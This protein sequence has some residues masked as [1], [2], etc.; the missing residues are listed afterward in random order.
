MKVEAAWCRTVGEDI[1]GMPGTV[2]NEA[3]LTEIGVAVE[4][5][6]LTRAVD[7]RTGQVRA[8]M[9][10]GLGGSLPSE[11]YLSIVAYLLQVNGHAA[12]PQALT[13]DAVA[14]VGE[15]G[16]APARGAPAAATYNTAVPT[17]G[18]RWRGG[19]A[20]EGCSG[21]QPTLAYGNRR[22]LRYGRTEPRAA[23]GALSRRCGD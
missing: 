15:P 14:I 19:C 11:T 13:A 3:T 17:G 7:D 2:E 5:M 23:P 21:S 8:E 10:P 9:P 12:G 20:V 1:A 6:T 22:V 18:Q 16:A 4:G